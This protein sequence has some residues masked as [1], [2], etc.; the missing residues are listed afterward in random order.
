[1]L[2]L[3]LGRVIDRGRR[4]NDMDLQEGSEQY[5]DIDSEQ[6]LLARRARH[7]H[8]AILLCTMSA[9]FV[10]LVI[11]ILFL[12]TLFTLALETM[13]A[14]LFMIAL[15]CLISG[16]LIFL[17]EIEL[18]ARAFR[19][20]RYNMITYHFNRSGLTLLMFINTRSKWIEEIATILA[21]TFILSEEG[22]ICPSQL[23]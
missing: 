18:S 17:K 5:A 8:R 10:C 16:L 15:L 11:V 19:F 21:A 6:K 23:S 4:L 2:S 20:G 13:I 12:D 1:V 22:S 14:V 3:R 7:I 9:L